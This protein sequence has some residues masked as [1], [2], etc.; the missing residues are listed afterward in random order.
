MF[1]FDLPLFHHLVFLYVCMYV[2]VS[3]IYTLNLSPAQR[4]IPDVGKVANQN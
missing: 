2:C 3:E 1:S 4:E